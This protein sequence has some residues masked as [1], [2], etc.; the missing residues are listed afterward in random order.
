MEKSPSVDRTTISLD[1]DIF[2]RAKDKAESKGMKFSTYVAGLIVADI[3]D[4]VSLPDPTDRDAIVD[5]ARKLIGEL[6]ARALADKLKGQNQPRILQ[7]WLRQLAE[8]GQGIAESKPSGKDI[9]RALR[10]Q[11]N[12]QPSIAEQMQAKNKRRSTESA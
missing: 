6:D 2:R 5:L 10:D 8:E 3:S 7:A 11:F 4:G 9:A 12:A 1:S